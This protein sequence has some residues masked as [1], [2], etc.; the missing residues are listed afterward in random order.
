MQFLF[1]KKKANMVYHVFSPT[2]F[3]ALYPYAERM[4]H[5]F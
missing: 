3:P 5:G 1:Y 2:S 4:N